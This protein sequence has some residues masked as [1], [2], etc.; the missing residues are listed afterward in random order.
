MAYRILAGAIVVLHLAVLAY[1]VFGGFLA[2]RR[3]RTIWLHL[4]FAGWGFSSIIFGLDCPL[5]AA[6]DWA[7][8]HAGLPSLPGGFIDTYLTG[9]LYPESAKTLV[10]YLAGGLVLASWTGFALLRRRAS[11]EVAGKPGA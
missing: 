8:R 6:E 2:W 7:R 9:T 3:P 5:T 11:R 4:A 1:V 10:Q